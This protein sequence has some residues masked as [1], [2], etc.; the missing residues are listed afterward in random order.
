MKKLFPLFTFLTILVVPTISAQQRYTISGTIVDARSHETLLGATVFEERSAKGST[1]NEYGFY[2]LT[3]PAGKVSIEASYVGYSSASATFELKRDT[4]INFRLEQAIVVEQITVYGNRRYHGALSPQM[5]AIE[6][7]IAQIKNTPAIFGEKDVLKAIQLLPGV[8]GGSEGS[9]GVYVR[10]G[11]QDENL[12]LLD[13]VPVYNVNHMFGFFSV[14]NPDAVKSVTL[15]KGSFPA[16]FGS[17]LSSV[18]DV[19]TLDGDMY[20]YHGNASIGLISSKINI[21][22]PIWKG[23]TSFN[24]SAR[25]TYADA[26]AVPAMAIVS[27]KE[28]DGDG[29]TIGGYYFYDLNAKLNHKFSD[30]DRLFLSFYMGDDKIYARIKTKDSTESD[31]TSSKSNMNL[32]WNWGNLITS[33]RWNHICSPRLFMD[34]SATFTRYRNRLGVG[35]DDTVTNKDGTVSTSSG[36]RADSGIYDWTGKVDFDWTPNTANNI[37]FGVAYVNHTFRPDVTSMNVKITQPVTG[38]GTPRD[39]TTIH[40]QMYGL[41]NIIAHE[42]SAYVE[43][44]LSLGEA[45]QADLGLH[46]SAFMVGGKFYNSLQPRLSA[47]LLL[48]D[49]FSFKAG[50]AYMSQYVHMLSN[51]SI[52]LPTD[53]WVPVTKRIKPMDSNQYSIGLFYDIPRLFDISVEGYYKKMNNLLEYKDGA[54]LMSTATGWEDKVCMGRGWAYGVEVLVQRSLGNTTGW[55]GYTWSRSMRLFDREGQV[56]NDGKPFPAK[57]DRRH[58]ISITVSHRFNEHIDVSATWVYNTGNCATLAL[59]NYI[60][61]EPDV[62]GTFSSGFS[63]SGYI[64][65]RNNYR[66]EPYHRLDLGFNYSY[67]TRRGQ[68]TWNLSVYNAYNNMNPFMIYPSED[69]K[70]DPSTGTSTTET[71]LKKITIFPIMPSISYS[72]K[73]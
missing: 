38:S 42:I 3:L 20:A 24:I 72:F 66:Y 26:L 19:R 69:V 60:A 57:Y 65:S 37:R 49:N 12:L 6:I 45:V 11:G 17:R 70:Y 71:K 31:G 55:I 58:D 13:G 10:G 18:I 51:N 59:Q 16:R 32:D 14:F 34:A 28:S 25:R 35:Y 61:P 53:L 63:S 4:M 21:E 2:S 47:R 64:S 62:E 30:T 7:P 67:R 52:S 29:K 9:A 56:I 5:G 48:A 50:Y 27:K 23:K 46:Y 36:V 41:N 15:F 8:Q 54:S 73:F 1:T 22:G 40:K 44:N 43:D 39:T 68:S 33:L